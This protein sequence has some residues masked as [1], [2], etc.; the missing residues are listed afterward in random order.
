MKNKGFTLVELTVVLAIVGVLAAILVPTLMG[1]VKK[2]R[3]KTANANAKTV[4]NVVAEAVAD[5]DAN[6]GSVDWTAAAGTY[7]GS[8]QTTGLNDD[9][10]RTVYNVL[11]P[12]SNKAGEVYI[13]SHR[14]G[15]TDGFFVHW[16]ESANNIIGQYPQAIQSTNSNVIWENFYE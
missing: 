4:Y 11:S 2:T 13:G 3:L 7:N 5:I 8:V 1:Y 6:E 12:N 10:A 9:F 16:R 15:N 14:F